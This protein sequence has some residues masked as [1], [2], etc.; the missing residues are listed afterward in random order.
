M[1]N[2]FSK[3]ASVIALVL[4]LCFTLVLAGCGNGSNNT[5]GDSGSTNSA[6]HSSD[7]ANAS[8]K[9][10]VWGWDKAWFEGTGAK[11]NEKFPNVKLEFVEVSAGDYLKKIQ[12]SIAA[13]YYL[14]RSGLP[15]RSV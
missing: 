10:T 7:P 8:G 12:T 5:S 14:G 13:G 3:K 2:L 11:F 15:R 6:D 1:H 9:L 4:T